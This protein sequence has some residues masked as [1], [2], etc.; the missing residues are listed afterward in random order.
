MKRLSF[1]PTAETGP[2]NGTTVLFAPTAETGLADGTTVSFT[3][4]SATAIDKKA[5]LQ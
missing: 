3:P 5:D 1:A 4:T 2:A